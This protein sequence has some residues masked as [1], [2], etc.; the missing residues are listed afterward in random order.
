M[1]KN[2]SNYDK[3]V[4]YGIGQNYHQKKQFI[5]NYKFDYLMDEKFED[6]REKVYDGIPI[7][8]SCELSKI[9]SCVI[10]VFPTA[11]SIFDSVRRK[12]DCDVIRADEIIEIQNNVTGEQLRTLLPLNK[13]KDSHGNEI[14]FDETIEKDILIHFHGVNNRVQ[15]GHNVT[16]SSLKIYCGNNGV[17]ILKDDS[18]I[19]TAQIN[20]S[21]GRVDIGRD[22]MIAKGVRIRN[23]DNHHIF[24]LGSGKR[25]NY[26]KNVLV[27]DCVWLGE[28]SVLLPGAE[29]DVGSIVAE[30]AVTSS[31]FPDHVILAGVPAKVIRENIIWSRDNTFYFD[32]DN[33]DECL[34]RNARNF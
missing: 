34:D 15:I 25:I 23:N 18:T 33:F 29:I 16:V 24:D 27:G 21:N 19:E 8:R 10:V 7:I 4:A 11:K 28:E 17:C 12:Y 1:K 13:Y 30:R 6:T 26:S 9:D 2:L 31:C 14:Y 22:C 32:R 5:T 3:I 20:V